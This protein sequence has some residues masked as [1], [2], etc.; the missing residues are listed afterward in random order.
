MHVHALKLSVTEQELN[1]LVAAL[2]SGHKSVQN[3]QVRLTSEGIVVQGEYAAMLMKM[4]FETL[5]E[6]KGAGSTVEARL[7][8]MKVASV[9][10]AMLRATLLKTLRDLLAREPGMRVTDESIYVDLSKITAIQKLRLN[11]HLTEVRCDPG[12][13]VIEAGPEAIV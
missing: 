4:A 12:K 6:V 7:V 9:P 13:L 2:P 3:L 1:E 11:F 10:A 5:W 8:S